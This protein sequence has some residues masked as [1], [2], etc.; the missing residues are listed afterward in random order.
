MTALQ[1]KYQV[2]L[3]KEYKGYSTEGRESFSD[4]LKQFLEEKQIAANSTP[5]Q[6][7]A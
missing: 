1:S 5:V 2:G 7:C 6:S 4:N 3:N